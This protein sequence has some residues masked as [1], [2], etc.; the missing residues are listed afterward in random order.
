MPLYERLK[1]DLL[2]SAKF[3]VDETPVPVLDP[4]AVRRR[5]VTS[6]RLRAMTG[7]GAEPTAAVVCTYAP[8]RRRALEKLL[9]NLAV[10]CSVTAMLLTR[11]CRRTGS[12]SPFARAT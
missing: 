3:A 1:A 8:G 5:P 9:T 12:Q 6:G 2:A 4:G 11:S 7:P 10:S